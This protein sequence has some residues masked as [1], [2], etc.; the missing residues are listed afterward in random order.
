MSRRWLGAEHPDWCA[1]GHLCGLGEHRAEPV[2]IDVP[3]HGRAVL[4]RAQDADGRQYA[5]IRLRIALHPAEPVARR[6][7]A[8]ALCDLRAL[9]TRAT[10]PRPR[11]NGRAA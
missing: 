11:P 8:S 6:Q 2:V 3:G 7:L 9:I 10:N 1:R 4:G 5:E